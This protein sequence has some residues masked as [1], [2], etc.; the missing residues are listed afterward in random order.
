MITDGTYKLNERFPTE[1]ELAERFG[2]GRSSV[3]EAIKTLSHLGIL[4]S[5][6]SQGTYISKNNRIAEVATA[7]SVILGY[8]KMQE[9]F[10]LGTALDSQ[11]AVILVTKLKD[12]WEGGD[13]LRRD[14]IRDSR[15]SPRTG[16]RARPR[17][18]RPRHDGGQRQQI[19]TAHGRPPSGVS[20]PAPPAAR[21]S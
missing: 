2:V 3:R 16:R 6:T 13:D 20:R 15:E 10:A 14:G 19:L 1:Q 12:R 17:K 8:E 5:H 11:V 9:I 21:R 18:P 4:E 7:W